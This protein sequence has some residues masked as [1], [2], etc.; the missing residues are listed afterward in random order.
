MSL[1]VAAYHMAHIFPSHGQ[2]IH[3]ESNC[4]SLEKGEEKFGSISQG[5]A[6]S[7]YYL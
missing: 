5:T 2:S 3:R 6:V 1:E 7:L 4:N